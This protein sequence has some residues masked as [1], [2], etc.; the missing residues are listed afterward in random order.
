[1]DTLTLP[2]NVLQINTFYTFSSIWKYYPCFRIACI[3]IE[4]DNLHRCN[5]HSD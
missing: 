5:S 1:M 3:F 2:Y 4:W